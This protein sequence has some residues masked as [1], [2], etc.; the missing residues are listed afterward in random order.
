MVN[1]MS[2][3]EKNSMPMK[4]FLP[5]FIIA[6]LS[7]NH[8]GSLER[9]EQ[10]VRAAADA[11]ADAVKLQTYTAD[12][13]TLACDQ[14]PFRINGTIW[15]GRTLYDLYRQAHTP[16]EWTPHLMALSNELG[17]ECFSTPFD[18]S[19]VDFLEEC[20]V[21]KYKV[22]S[23]EVVDIPLLKKIAGTGKPVIMS[24]GMATLG[25]IDEAVRTLR[26][27]GTNE[28]TLL[29]CTSAY[30]APAEEANLRTIPHLAS[31]FGCRAGLSD[32]TR[33]NAVSIA[34]VAL[35]ATVIERHFTLSRADG[36]P[37]ASF[38]MEPAEFG[39]MVRDIRIVE[40]SLGRIRYELTPKE[41]ESAVFRRS[42]FAG[43]DIRK[44]ESFTSENIRC[45]RPGNGLPPR[46]MDI[47]LG[48]KAPI[49]IKKGSPLSWDLL[50]G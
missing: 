32:H 36:G 9:A 40:K 19:A 1:I 41:K 39:Q 11:G 12:T 29:K 18:G 48:K 33:G 45:I 47:L 2:E 49:D 31:T 24:T 25:E 3:I 7:A 26:E 4:T 38:S 6:E 15:A 5:T 37:D 46:Y 17:M 21:R 43:N 10:I 22:A 28:I 20:G 8:N 27:N 34:A 23:F 14:P 30:P 50:L 13:M 44:G 16:W 42:L 35:G